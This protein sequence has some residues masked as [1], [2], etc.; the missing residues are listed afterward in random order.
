[1]ISEPATVFVWKWLPGACD[2]VVCGRLDDDGT[3]I[4]FTYARSFRERS[5]A[6]P[7][8]L[9]ELPLTAG[10]HYAAAGDRL[11]L[12]IDDA[13][14]DSWG[15]R[16]I[17]HRLGQPTA[18]LP[19]LTYLLESGSDRIGSLDFQTSPTMYV[20]RAVSHPSLDEL[21]EAAYRLQ[22][23]LP[24]NKELEDALAHGSEIGGARPKALVHQD[25]RTF[26]AKFESSADTFPVVQGEFVAM[27][28]AA[29]AGVDAAPVQLTRAAGRYTLLVQRFDRDGDLRRGVV[30]ALTIL[31]MRPYPEGRYATY[32]EFADEI[33]ARF[34][35]PDTTLRELFARISFSILCGNTD[36]HGRNH[37]AF[38]GPGLELVLTPAYDICPQARTGTTA[39]QAMGFTA[40]GQ[41]D[42][43]IALLVGAAAIFH[44][45]AAQATAVVDAQV[46][47]IRDN[48][49]SVCTE[50]NLTRA[51][52]DAFMGT[53]FLNP[54]VFS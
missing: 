38:T 24:L 5:G 31:G 19:D 34:T 42:S 15:R 12:A 8:Y 36:D 25:G 3:T 28:L 46:N 41:R 14:P 10:Q 40:D 27:R 1:M 29:L 16:V 49:D 44:L 17:N 9:P 22:E 13:M 52:R 21:N 20:P 6:D 2:P 26:I 53:Q 39:R 37:A 35:D 7:I 54:Y 4:S 18:E 32:T 47:T 48:W 11:P 43:R 33:R 23:G 50:A 45:T 51:Q 30:S